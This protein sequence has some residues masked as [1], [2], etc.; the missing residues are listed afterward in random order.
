MDKFPVEI[1]FNGPTGSG[2]SLYIKLL[3]EQLKRLNIN[4]VMD[5]EYTL[6]VERYDEHKQ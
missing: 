6:C 1:S 5:G 4:Y 3:I 2:R